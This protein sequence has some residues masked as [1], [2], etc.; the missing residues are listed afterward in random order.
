MK[1]PRG[2]NITEVQIGA[3]RK[4]VPGDVA[5]CRCRCTRRKGD[6]VFA[7]TDQEPYSIRVGARDSCIGIE[8]G[9]IGMQLGGK[10]L[11]QVPPHLTYVERKIYPD[12]PEDAMLIY[13]IEL[14]DLPTK[15]DVEMEHRLALKAGE[16]NG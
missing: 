10:R 9:L 5:V 13:E 7:S 2:L 15:W 4:V 6:L 11:I 12:L 3:G 16:R 1:P 14:I 8:Y